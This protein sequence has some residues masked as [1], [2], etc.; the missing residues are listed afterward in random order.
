MFIADKT[1]NSLSHVTFYRCSVCISEHVSSE[2]IVEHAN[3]DSTEYFDGSSEG[4]KRYMM[5]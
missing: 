2:P 1:T 4:N 5:I 3:H